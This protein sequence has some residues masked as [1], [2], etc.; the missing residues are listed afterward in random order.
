MVTLARP[1]ATHRGDE[2]RRS[3]DRF[4]RPRQEPSS[5]PLSPA[6]AR[7]F[8]RRARRLPAGGGIL[9]RGMTPWG[10]DWGRGG[11][12]EGGIWDEAARPE[13]GFGMRQDSR[14]GYFGRLGV[15]KLCV[16]DGRGRI[17]PF[18]HQLAGIRAAKRRIQRRLGAFWLDRHLCC[19]IYTAAVS[20]EGPFC[21]SNDAEIAIFG[22][23]ISNTQFLHMQAPA[24]GAPVPE[25]AHN[26]REVLHK[27]A[28]NVHEPRR[29]P[30]KPRRELHE[31]RRERHERQ[32][33]PHEPQRKRYA[34]PGGSAT[35]PAK[36][37]A[38]PGGSATGPGGSAT[39]AGKG[40]ANPG[41]SS[42]RRP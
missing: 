42:M 41:G 3:A 11:T 26:R 8:G 16:G 33:G 35:G 7:G 36:G 27:S 4:R 9:G 17:T 18:A 2:G 40:R 1:A 28:E 19:G 14:R 37:R 39:S 13:A 23:K 21:A 31:P 34:N 25:N 20:S 29:G 22:L 12:P 24:K 15:E 30:H 32:Q 10:L 38:N 6:F 5:R